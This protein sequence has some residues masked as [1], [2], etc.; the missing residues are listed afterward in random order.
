MNHTIFFKIPNILRISGKVRWLWKFFQEYIYKKNSYQLLAY[1]IYFSVSVISPFTFSFLIKF[2][3]VF[4]RLKN[5]QTRVFRAD[6]TNSQPPPPHRKRYVAECWTRT[7]RFDPSVL[8]VGFLVQNSMWTIRSSITIPPL[9]HNY[10]YSPTIDAT[11]SR[12]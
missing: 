10:T 8:H 6:K 2:T 3:Y 12:C 5:A 9:L 4:F 11:H 7:P 1:I